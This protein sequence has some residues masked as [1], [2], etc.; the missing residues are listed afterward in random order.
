MKWE[1]GFLTLSII[2]GKCCVLD[3]IEEAPA[4]ITERLNGLLDKNLNVESDLIFEIPEC[5]EKKEVKIN[6]NLRLICICNYNSISKMSP[7]FLNRFDIITLEDQLKPLFKLEN[8]EKYFLALIDTLMKQHSFN[9]HLNKINNKEDKIQNDESIDYNK[10]VGLDD[11]NANKE[12][13]K[14]D[15]EYKT[16][17]FINKL[18]LKDIS[19]DIQNCNLSIYK[20]SLFCRAVHIFNN[21]LVQIRNYL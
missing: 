16:N 5:H 4:T 18:I 7:A 2:Q 3:N 6:K 9:Y 10:Y 1:D 12:N 8:N 13:K 11:S 20:L 14:S 21:E 15:Y 19:T 17:K